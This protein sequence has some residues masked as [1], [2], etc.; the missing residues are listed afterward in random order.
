MPN[1]GKNIFDDSITSIGFDERN[2]FSAK[3]T[4]I[5][6]SAAARPTLT[7]QPTLKRAKST[8]EADAISELVADDTT[9]VGLTSLEKPLVAAFRAIVLSRALQSS[10]PVKRTSVDVFNDPD[11]RRQQ[12]VFRIF[13]DATSKQAL[14][15]WNSMEHE[16]AT[17]STR[18]EQRRL[19]LVRSR[20]SL[21]VHWR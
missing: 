6:D 21:R 18:L 14:A 13:V 9:P 17:W 15:F 2:D 1:R 12:I 4:V 11:D 8:D 3:L 20:L 19:R 5:E 7:G 10:I 16:F